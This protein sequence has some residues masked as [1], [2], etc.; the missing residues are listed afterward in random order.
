MPNRAEILKQQFLQSLGFPWQSILSESR[1]AEILEEENIRY[2][3]SVYTPVNTL[4]AMISQALDPDKSLSNA[5]KQMITWL[6]PA[7]TTCPSADTGAY[8][9]A[10]QRLPESLLQRLLPETGESLESKCVP[11]A[12]VRSSSASL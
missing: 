1:L 9:K 8:S 12:M 6:S 4:W 3:N 5:V 2:R 7:G 10:R 11:P